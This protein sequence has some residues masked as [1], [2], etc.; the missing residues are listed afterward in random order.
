MFRERQDSIDRAAVAQ[1]QCRTRT[2]ST[3]EDSIWESFSWPKQLRPHE[4]EL[5]TKNGHFDINRGGPSVPAEKPGN[6]PETQMLRSA[7][8]PCLS[9]RQLANPQTATS[10][11]AHT[12][13]LSAE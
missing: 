5:S 13:R 7:S 12:V 6:S 8:G 1:P 3:P 10:Y 11:A 2:R 9:S 4:T